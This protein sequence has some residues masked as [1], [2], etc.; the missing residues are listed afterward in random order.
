[1]L[2]DI[3]ETEL[4]AAAGE[5]ETSLIEIRLLDRIETVICKAVEC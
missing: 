5:E 2:D 3:L 1:M 4:A